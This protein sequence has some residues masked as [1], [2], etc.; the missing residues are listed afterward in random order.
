MA[1]LYPIVLVP[2]EPI[3]LDYWCLSKRIYTENLNATFGHTEYV[4]AAANFYFPTIF[5]MS[6]RNSPSSFE[7]LFASFNENNFAAFFDIVG[8]NF[9]VTRIPH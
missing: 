4:F 8:A 2:K 3:P 1:R 9:S 6:A 7:R 5:N